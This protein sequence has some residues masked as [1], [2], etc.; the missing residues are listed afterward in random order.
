MNFEMLDLDM[1][2]DLL[3]FYSKNDYLHVLEGGLWVILGH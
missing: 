3:R 1:G 2:Y